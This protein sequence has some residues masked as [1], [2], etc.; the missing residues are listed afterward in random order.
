MPAAR[1]LF[2]I[3]VGCGRMGSYIANRLSLDGHS[4]VVIDVKESAFKGL[5]A[6]FS[7]FKM[8]GDATEFE[9]LK[10]AKV[11]K[12]DLVI[13]TT[14]QDNVNVMVAQ[15]ARHVLHVPKVIARVFEPK[16]ERV[17]RELDIEIISSRAARGL[18]SSCWRPS[19]VRSGRGSPL[20]RAGA[21]NWRPTC[22]NRPN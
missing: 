5:S 13:A 1:K 16:R 20:R 15:V 12:A 9:T 11:E 22:V 4:V 10:Q 8:E 3:V 6:E 18:P 19:R 14:H 17:Y 2:V 7:G 21:I